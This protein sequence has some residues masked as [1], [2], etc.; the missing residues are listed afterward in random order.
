VGG[1]HVSD[2]DVPERA[3]AILA[4]CVGGSIVHTF[5]GWR[6]A[7]KGKALRM[8]LSQ[9]RARSPVTGGNFAIWGGLFSI[10]DCSLAAVR[11]TEDAWNAIASG[12]LT[13]AVLAARAGPR[14]MARSAAIGAVLLAVIE[15]AS[16]FL[17]RRIAEWQK[18][19]AKKQY[20]AIHGRPL[21]EDQ[22]VDKLE[23]PIKPP[24]WHG[25]AAATDPSSLA[26]LNVGMDRA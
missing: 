26:G 11:R 20:E 23:P 6:N 12:G 4:G 25:D 10:F 3:L 9:V 1:R 15:G 21:D 13:G 14:A 17:Q 8:A 24:V 19:S 2:R 22:L 18:A 5:K 7:P 16:V